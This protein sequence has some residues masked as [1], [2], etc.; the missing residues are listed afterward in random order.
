MKKHR[1]Q[2]TFSYD[3]AFEK[4]FCLCHAGLACPALDAGIRHLRKMLKNIYK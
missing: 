4:K 3:A 1:L 2:I